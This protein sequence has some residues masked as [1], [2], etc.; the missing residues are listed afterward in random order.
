MGSNYNSRPLLPEI[1]VIGERYY[2]IR[3]RQ[4]LEQMVENEVIPE[5]LR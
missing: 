5:E 2:E 4:T 3:K 1:M